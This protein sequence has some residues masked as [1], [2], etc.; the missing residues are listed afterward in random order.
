MP[1]EILSH[2]NRSDYNKGCPK[3]QIFGLRDPDL[4]AKKMMLGQA[5]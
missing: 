5:P 2:F 1:Q 3:S 4:Y